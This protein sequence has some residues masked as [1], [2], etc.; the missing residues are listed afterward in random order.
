MFDKNFLKSTERLQ[1]GV[2]PKSACRSL[3]RS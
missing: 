2:L 3:L 1:P